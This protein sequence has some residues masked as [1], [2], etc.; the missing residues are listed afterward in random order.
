LQES[1]K[2]YLL[3]YYYQPTEYRQEFESYSP[4]LLIFIYK[5]CI[6]EP[7]NQKSTKI[8][9]PMPREV[10]NARTLIVASSIAAIPIIAGSL[11][12]TIY[13]KRRRT[14]ALSIDSGGEPKQRNTEKIIP[15]QTLETIEQQ[16]PL[17]KVEKSQIRTA[18]TAA[19]VVAS[20]IE[21][22]KERPTTITTT[23]TT[24]TAVP[25]QEQQ[26]ISPEEAPVPTKARQAGESLKEL[27]VTA[28]REAKGSAK[29]TG[30][31]LKERTVDIAAT[32][33]SKDIRSLGSD[34][35]NMTGLFED[36]MAEIRKEGYDE[37][38]T[39]LDSYKRLL[40]KQIRVLDAGKKLASKL[41]PGA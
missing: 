34:V 26:R 10:F 14:K 20:S 28:A 2:S 41:K 36:M 30:R 7:L 3:G 6:I 23:T 32:A 9:Q 31:R 39:L 15:M 24:P 1:K 8:G 12:V 16:Q 37:Q 27:F 13:Q 33:D 19:A 35:E 40:L 21:A 22:S 25:M 11:Y 29:K 18:V 4:R 38:V 5:I 17:Q